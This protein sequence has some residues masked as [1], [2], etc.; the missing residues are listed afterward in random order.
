MDQCIVHFESRPRVD[1]QNGEGFVDDVKDG[2]KTGIS[3]VSQFFTGRNK[4]SPQAQATLDKYAD[5]IVKSILV[6]REP[7]QKFIDVFM[8]LL[9]AGEIKRAQKKYGYDDLYHLFTF[10]TLDNGAKLI[11]EKQQTVI[12]KA[13][14]SNEKHQ[15]SMNVDMKNT[16]PSLF[17]LI[18]NTRIKMGSHFLHYT[19]NQYNCQDFVHSLL[20]SNGLM[21]EELRLFINQNI[22]ELLKYAPVAKYAALGATDLKDRIDV[23]RGHGKNIDK[24]N[25]ITKKKMPNNSWINH[26]KDYA[27]KNNV[28]YREAMKL[29]G[30]SYR[31]LNNVR[32]PV[33]RPVK[34]G[35]GFLDDLN[36]AF[37]PNKNG[38]AKAFDPKRNGTSKAFTAE[39]WDPKKNGVSQGFTAEVWDP[40]K[41]GAEKA[42]KDW[43]LASNAMKIAAPLVSMGLSAIPIVGAPLSAVASPAINVAADLLKEKTGFGKRRGRKGGMS[44]KDLVNTASHLIHVSNGINHR[45]KKGG[46]STKSLT[47]PASRLIYSKLYSHGTTRY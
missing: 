45:R 35:G 15:K 10:V 19:A 13:V 38:A 34:R 30:P 24:A 21:T 23:L 43:H 39:V 14:S 33:K 32:K 44:T 47:D 8:Q 17:Q 16:T 5:N 9:S 1:Y 26:C 12:I 6:C 18:N 28:S 20:S 27:S 3:R 11:I 46:M 40:K 7:V 2:I 4:L 42:G 25:N 22:D 31:S 29:A 36:R 41:N 37:D